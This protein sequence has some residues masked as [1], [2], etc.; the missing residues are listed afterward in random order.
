MNDQEVL[1]S[2]LTWLRCLEGV[3]KFVAS[4]SGGTA[5]LM[6]LALLLLLLGVSGLN[7]VNS[8]VGRNFMTAIAER[9][10]AGFIGQA[11]LYIMVFAASTAVAV[12]YRFTEERLGLLWR[13]WL[14]RHLVSAY[15]SDRT[16]HRLNDKL[17]QNGEIAN[18][19]Q[20]IADDVRTFTVST[21]SLVLM[22]LNSL[23]TIIAFAGVMWTI[24]PLLFVVTVGYS[25]AGSYF[26]YKLGRPL[27]GL[28][29][30]QFDREANFRSSLIHVRQNA[31]AIALSRREGRITS[32]LLRRVEEFTGNFRRIISVNRNLGFFTTGYNYMIQIIPAL[33][34]APMYIRGE[35]E[36]GVITQSAMAFA[37]LVGA[38]SLIVN[39]FQSISSYAAVAAR[40]DRL[41]QAIE[42]AKSPEATD[43][44]VAE[45]PDCIGFE[46][47]TL[48]SPEDSKVLVRDLSIRVPHGMRLL[49]SGPNDTAKVALLR[50]TAGIWDAGQGQ[51]IR[52]NLDTVRFLPERP[53]LYPGTLRELLLRSG[54]EFDVPEQRILEI[55][56]AL[57]LE[58]VME[59]AGGLDDEQDWASVLS[60]GE[61][62]LLA[63]TRLLLA[64]P[65]FAFL[66]RVCTALSDEQVDQIHK[67]L[68]AHGISY[69]SLEEEGTLHEHYDFVLEL[70]NDG[71]WGM[72]KIENGK[73]SY[74][75]VG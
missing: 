26:A 71:S 67:M 57:G 69:V 44:V 51:I 20:R 70:E 73:I 54:E 9:D 12:F 49:I 29:Y 17:A 24:S 7:V 36:F 23:I 45:D 55:L 5:K 1:V 35:V 52:P 32:Q 59:R 30:N 62:Q 6:A 4:D 16:Y 46:N 41:E 39:Q 18:P 60:L 19:D 22:A 27:V 11:M 21:L 65:C 53:Y 37:H 8:Y 34:V 43:I 56:Q 38:F 10:H 68:I 66:D 31:E 25:I 50:A 63:F 13:E 42:M 72:K 2:K 47:L 40:L 3:K 75:C 33:V 74:E 61:E 48:Y 15:L 58:A 64:A 14:T 28:N